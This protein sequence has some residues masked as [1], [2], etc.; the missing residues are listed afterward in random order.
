MPYDLS[1]LDVVIVED[2]DYMSSL[3]VNMMSALGAKRAKK[4]KCAKDLRNLL[5][6]NKTNRV[7]DDI[8]LIFLD[9]LYEN[10]DFSGLD[11]LNWLRNSDECANSD[12]PVIGVS[13][14]IDRET[15]VAL[16]NFGVNELIAKPFSVSTITQKLTT[17]FEHPR[18]FIVSEGYNGPCRRRRQDPH[19]S[20]EDRR[21]AK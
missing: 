3:L 19:Y 1:K 9:I 18:E 7:P 17:L 16:R 11:F 6:Y 2:S 8:N 12:I 13:G 5:S 10:D 15:L 20:G 14:L 4:F 21:K